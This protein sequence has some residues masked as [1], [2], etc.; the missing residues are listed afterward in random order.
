MP[1]DKKEV[2]LNNLQQSKRRS[3]PTA[4]SIRASLKEKYPIGWSKKP[5]KGK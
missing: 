2:H 4:E 1:K 5:N 3:S